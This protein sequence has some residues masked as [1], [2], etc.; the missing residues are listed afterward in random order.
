M[1]VF[2]IGDL[3][4]RFMLRLPNLF[5]LGAGRCGTTYLHEQLAEHPDIFMSAIKEPTFFCDLCGMG[6]PW[7][8]LQQFSEAG[9]ARVV[10]ESSHAYLSS[11]SSPSMLKAYVPEAKFLLTFRNPVDRAYSL[12]SWMTVAG[13]EWSSSFEGALG[14]EDKRFHS[15][16]FYENNPQYFYNYLYYRSGLFGEQVQRYLELFSKEQFLFLK[17]DDL[18]NNPRVWFTKIFRFLDVDPELGAQDI[19]QVNQSRE[20]RSASLQYFIGQYLQPNL[21]RLRMPGTRKFTDFLADLNVV[22][23]RPEQ[24]KQQTRMSLTDRYRDDLTLLEELTG[25]DTLDW[26]QRPEHNFE[27]I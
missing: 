26:R 8:Y 17:F 11:P 13:L 5:I 25:I 6:N 2:G 12:Y 1:L 24:L 18:I 22:H 4:G 3:L 15:R 14:R 7:E 23:T 10:G 16:R 9:A 19:G 27:T 20:V 21:Y